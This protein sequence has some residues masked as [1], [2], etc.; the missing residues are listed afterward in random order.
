MNVNQFYSSPFNTLIRTQS[1]EAF[2]LGT[3]PLIAVV[4]VKRK[5]Q[6]TRK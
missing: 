2:L 1:V 6:K 4:V 5:N 3:D